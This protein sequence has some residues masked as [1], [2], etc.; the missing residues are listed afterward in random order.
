MNNLSNPFFNGNPNGPQGIVTQNAFPAGPVS[1]NNQ[2]QALPVQNTNSGLI[3]GP[4]VMNP[5]AQAFPV[6][7][8][9]PGLI[10]GPFV[11]NPQAQAFPLQNANP[12]LTTGPFVM[13][14][15]AQAF[16][17]QNAN[18]APFPALPQNPQN[19]QHSNITNPYY[20]AAYGPQYAQQPNEPFMAGTGGFGILGV[21]H[22]G[23]IRS[24]N[25]DETSAETMF[26]PTA[27]YT[28]SEK[29]PPNAH[30]L[31]AHQ[32]VQGGTTVFANTNGLTFPN[33][34]P[35]PSVHELAERNG[36]IQAAEGLISGARA[37]PPGFQTDTTPP[38]S[39]HQGPFVNVRD[40]VNVALSSQTAYHHALHHQRVRIR[41]VSNWIH[42]RRNTQRVFRSGNQAPLNPPGHLIG[43]QP[44]NQPSN[45]QT[46]AQEPDSLS[47]EEVH[48]TQ[49]KA[50]GLDSH[51]PSVPAGPP[52]RYNERDLLQARLIRVQLVAGIPPDEVISMDSWSKEQARLGERRLF[53][54]SVLKVQKS[55]GDIS[56]PQITPA[57]FHGRIEPLPLDTEG[58]LPPLPNRQ[59]A[60][61]VQ[62]TR[63]SGSLVRPEGVHDANQ[64]AS[65]SNA[66]ASGSN[67]GT[68][69]SN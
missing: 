68:S 33:R 69:G 48:D 21:P 16:P 47:D 63:F 1:V 62:S 56:I 54:P 24:G 10:T 32:G 44:P 37:P 35:S 28:H 46:S 18:P 38:R 42:D 40:P 31:A 61:N 64:G 26:S 57:R 67:P 51:G 2:A 9:N 34:M 65:G 29:M 43:I 66:E 60:V 13:N 25:P 19:P 27:P 17:V 50:A 59:P 12:G 4:F 3:T 22:G 55:S 36:Q 15:Q 53:T 7:N 14:P 49:S 41:A 23:V 52:Q 39:H 5:Q 45:P 6:Q 30:F 11:M 8:A 20:M 58:W